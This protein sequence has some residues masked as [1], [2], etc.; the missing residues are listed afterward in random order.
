MTSAFEESRESVSNILFLITVGAGSRGWWGLPH[1][2]LA[3]FFHMIHPFSLWQGISFSLSFSFGIIVYERKNFKWQPRFQVPCRG[4]RLTR[5][6]AAA[7]P[8]TT[9]STGMMKWKDACLYFPT[10]PPTSFP[11]PPLVIQ[12]LPSFIFVKLC[13]LFLN[14]LSCLCAGF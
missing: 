14:H 6:A 11:C 8:A 10:P 3:F 1:S 5:I 4:W 13:E 9:P 12:S 7:A 2:W